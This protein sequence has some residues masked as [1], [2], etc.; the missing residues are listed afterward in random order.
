MFK[1]SEFFI[2]LMLLP[3]V[4]FAQE[5]NPI[6]PGIAISN[7]SVMKLFFILVG[8]LVLIAASAYFLKRF[9]NISENTSGP[10]QVIAQAPMGVK[11]RIIL[12][13]VGDE[14]LLVG[15]SLAGLQTLHVLEKPLQD[16]KNTAAVTL[17]FASALKS[18]MQR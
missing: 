5:K 11:E 2:V 16:K 9:T 8:V 4:L 10:I 17:D 1:K 18:V 15:Q 6:K 13:Q 3:E 14:Q 7:D 12:L